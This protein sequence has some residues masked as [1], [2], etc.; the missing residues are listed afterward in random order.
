VGGQFGCRLRIDR[1]AGYY[2][3]VALLFFA[4]DEVAAPSLVFALLVL[5]TAE[6]DRFH[7]DSQTTVNQHRLSHIGMTKTARSL[8]GG[9]RILVC[10]PGGAQSLKNLIKIN[11]TRLQCELA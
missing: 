3:S 1:A 4:G 7:D 10:E 11:Y 5:V 2:R 8:A 6:C 9:V